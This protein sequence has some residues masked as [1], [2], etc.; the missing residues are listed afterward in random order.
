MPIIICPSRRKKMNQKFMWP[1]IHQLTLKKKTQN[2]SVEFRK[3]FKN[4]Q[5]F[6]KLFLPLLD[7][8][9]AS[10]RESETSSESVVAIEKVIFRLPSSSSKRKTRRQLAVFFV[11]VA[12]T[13]ASPICESTARA[14]TFSHFHIA[15][16]QFVCRQQAT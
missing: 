9:A 13:L 3:Y 15:P 7:S 6:M 14:S 8:T 10:K 2:V 4:T 1:N 16:A 5:S 12:C 11:V